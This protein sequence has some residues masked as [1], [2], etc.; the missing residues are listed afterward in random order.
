MA[1]DLARDGIR[2]MAIMPGL[3]STPTVDGLPTHTRETLAKEMTFPARLGRAEEF[4]ELVVSI[5]G[6][7]MLNGS[8]IRLDGAFRM[9]HGRR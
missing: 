8:A 3:F 6:N 1:R 9:P 5:V 7:S 4:A 2:V